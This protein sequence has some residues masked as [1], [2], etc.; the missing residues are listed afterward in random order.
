MARRKLRVLIDLSLA[1]R[2]YR[3]TSQDVRLL[4]KS[5]ASCPELD[6]TGLVYLPRRL[7]PLHKFLPATAARGERL[8][9]QACFLWEFNEDSANWPPVKP[10]RMLQQL[11][12]LASTVLTSRI[13]LDPLDVEVLW[14]VV[15]RLLFSPT[16]SAADIPL[17]R[18]GKFLLSNISDGM[19]HARSLTN[20]R[21]L[22]LDTLGYDFFIVQGPRPFRISPQTCQILR[23]YDLIP[24]IR[25]DMMKN[26]WY[27]KWHHR[28]IRQNLNRAVYVCCSEPT[29]DD[30]TMA[31]PEL[32]ARS[33]T[34]PCML[35][36]AYRPDPNPGL[37][38]S[39][40]EMRR[41][42][43]AGVYSGES[44]AQC[45]QYI[46]S[47]STLEPRKNL[48][49]LIEAFNML[50]RRS[51]VGSGLANLKLLIVGS[52]GW[53]YEPIL[54]AMRH[55][56]EQGELV[57][58]EKVP[59]EEARVLY[60]H[61]AAFVFPSNYEGFGFPPVEAMQC[62]APV[63]ASDISAHR[64]VLGDAALYCDPYDVTS[65]AAA[66]QRLVA[67]GESAELRASLV[68]RG[69][70]RIKLYD[71][72]R[73]CRAW[74]DLLHRLHEDHQ[75]IERAGKLDPAG[76]DLLGRVA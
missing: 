17:V 47:V 19:I 65:I 64:W 2:G 25:P 68:A 74:V 50:K 32:T 75:R 61:A 52:P 36:E 20:R 62:G 35:S 48:V 71:A 26:P 12:Q 43:A 66:I 21:P 38:R 67:S 23:Y 58:L 57:H 46:L 60:T 14:D 27:I 56:V 28:A 59:I 51:A 3:G 29:R 69:H 63:I 31:Y 49:G 72:D 5:L 10:L 13:Q 53:K 9:N 40:I 4:Y 18:D 39:I 11:R 73:C 8:A 34:I 42:T 1:A 7:R 41:S 76:Q 6:V 44:S 45:P 54:A 24:M 70:E 55:L 22:K 37:V 15:W 33:A 30:L 16:L